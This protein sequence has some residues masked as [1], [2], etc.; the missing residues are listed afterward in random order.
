MLSEYLKKH[1]IEPLLR[2]KGRKLFPS[3]DDRDSWDG[4][5]AE[6][7]EEIRAL[8]VEYAA[9][10]PM[11]TATE[12]LAYVRND[13]R[14]ADEDPYFFR[15]RKLCASVLACCVFPEAPIDPVIDG[16][17]C[18]AEETSW[19]VSAH[20]VNP[21]PGAPAPAEYP[22]PDPDD[23]YV[24]LF[25]AQTGMILSLTLHLLGSRLDAETPMLRER[26]VREIRRR[27]LEPFRRREDF[28]WM[29]NIRKD[30]C[31]WT[32]WIL[33][34]ILVCAA[35]DPMPNH[36]LAAIIERACEMLDR[37]L[38]IIPEDGGCDEGPGYWNMAGGSLMD[39]LEFLEKLTGGDS[40]AEG[41]GEHSAWTAPLLQET[42]IRNL[43]C[44]PRNAALG[45]GWFANFAD[46]DARPMISGERL[47]AAGERLG[48]NS[49][50]R[51][52]A[53][54]RGSLRDQLSDLPHLTRALKL[55]F[56][57]APAEN[58]GEAETYGDVWLP[59]LQMRIVR[60]G[61]F[62]LA[63][64]GGHNGENHNHNDVGSFILT[65]EGEPEIVDAGNMLYSAKTFSSRRYT[66][67]NVRAAY[68]NLPLIGSF[69]E[70][71]GTEYA[72]RNAETT[73]NGFSLDLA[74]AYEKAA[75]IR[76]L[77]RTFALDED[78]LILTDDI[79]LET[80]L[81]VTW[82][83]MLR[84]QPVLSYGQADTGR[85][86][87]HFPEELEAEVE[88]IRM[89][90]ARMAGIWHDSL[91]RLLLRGRPATEMRAVFSV[92]KKEP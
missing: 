68:H 35:L 49:L 48:D 61:T 69:E 75:G 32:P 86:I 74:A 23:P 22:L 62:V 7:R 17:W 54:M 5:T 80:G 37:Y 53:R 13:S 45:G 58:G 1:P 39:F 18:I 6:Q 42:K 14:L 89:T 65:A 15:R 21:I 51:L 92:R 10:Y 3:A 63:C 85:I 26:I 47:Q 56:H 72:A 60:R 50:I 46:S 57:P 24:D 91:W 38:D 29:G 84:H 82:V 8:N 64:K 59:D 2:Q 11:R 71:E 41:S 90:D 83:F 87:L 67:W 81:P 52:G 77:R 70:K 4:I 36:E 20:N 43:L 25:S 16:I 12:F 28:W 55:I 79:S 9:P 66:L 27:I 76:S 44:F 34:N 40:V 31:N 88:E 78:G 19:V 30:L 33:S 73:E